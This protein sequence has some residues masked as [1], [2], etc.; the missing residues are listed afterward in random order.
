MSELGKNE[1]G[2]GRSLPRVLIVED[3]P[4]VAAL[5]QAIFKPIAQI[6]GSYTNAADAKKAIQEA[7]KKGQSFDLVITD[8]GLGNNLPGGEEVVKALDEAFV[9]PDQRPHIILLTGSQGKA[10][11]IFPSEEERNRLKMEI[12]EKPLRVAAIMTK[13]EEIRASKNSLKAQAP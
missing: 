4:G 3:E 9:D 10:N 6:S 12:W 8:L 2:P 5:L 13:I 11:A 1:L 7:E